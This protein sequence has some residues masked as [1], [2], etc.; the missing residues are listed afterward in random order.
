MC[1]AVLRSEHE[2]VTDEGP[3]SSL[4]VIVVDSSASKKARHLRLRHRSPS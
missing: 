3:V 2:Q 1:W 4:P